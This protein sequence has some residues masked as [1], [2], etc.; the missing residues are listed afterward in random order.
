MNEK[1][2]QRVSNLLQMARAHGDA[3][4]VLAITPD[5]VLWSVD[6]RITIPDLR[7][8]L[9]PKNVDRICELIARE[10]GARQTAG[11]ER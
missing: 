10:R 1:T 3:I 2:K 9:S 8:L 7:G 5:D 11:V 6:S 4:I